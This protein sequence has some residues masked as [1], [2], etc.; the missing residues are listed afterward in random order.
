VPPW[1]TS[2]CQS[3][4]EGGQW[5][6]KG[7]LQLLGQFSRIPGRWS[8]LALQP[9]LSHIEVTG[10]TFVMGRPIQGHQRCG[11]LGPAESQNKDDGGSPPQTGAIS[12]GYLA[13]AALRR[14]WCYRTMSGVTMKTVMYQLTME[15][16]F[17][18][19]SINVNGRS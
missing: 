2:L 8:S 12:G 18:V 7:P 6:N 14:E 4:P 1:H 15:N 19:L 11:L 5:Q 17:I 9:N 13:C 10:A 16:S 3:T